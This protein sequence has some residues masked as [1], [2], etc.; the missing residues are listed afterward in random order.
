MKKKLSMIV[1]GTIFISYIVLLIAS[2]I[3]IRNIGLKGATEKALIAAELVKDGLTAHMVNGIMA[4]RDYFLGQISNASHIDELW[5]TRSPSVV[6]Q[7]GVG[8]KNEIS[9]DSIDTSVLE[10]GKTFSDVFE[11]TT[12]T[13][14]R[15]TLPYVASSSSNP[16]CLSCHDAKEGDVLG[17]I[18]VIIDISDVKV[19]GIMTSAV[20]L[21]ISLVMMFI[22]FIIISRSL[23]PLAVLFESIT[24][25]MGSA[26]EGDYSKRV[27]LIN[28]SQEYKN[29]TF[30]INSLL[31]KL[32]D[33]LMQIETT[34]K[35][36][37]AHQRSDEKDMLIELK[38]LIKEISDLHK[39]KKTIEFD[40]DK[41][42]VYTRI[43]TVLEQRFD[44][45]NF[46]L[47]EHDKRN[48]IGVQIVYGM[49]NDG[50]FTPNPQCR[51]L[52]TKQVVNSEQ[53]PNIC[54]QCSQQSSHYLC[55]PFIVSSDIEILLHVD[56]NTANEI[57]EIHKRLIGFEN[58]INEA[59]PEIVSKNLTE[60]LRISSTTDGLTGLYNRKY[61]D[62]YIDKAT[63]QAKRSKTNFGVL[64][65]DIDYFK[66]VNDTYGHDIGDEVIRVLSKIM[67]N[68]I[69]ESDI[70]FRFGGEEF[71]IL[72]HQ[73]TSDKAE[74]I[75]QKIR[76]TFEQQSIKPANAQAFSKTLSIGVSI[77]PDDADSLWKTI[78]YADISLYRAKE[79]GRNK[80]VRFDTNF[81]QDGGVSTDF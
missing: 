10:N 42:Q 66:M 68:S 41:M 55:I 69:R 64:M 43:G 71:L 26:Q 57:A 21:V 40:E 39:F 81:L 34:V 19:N 49:Q 38:D 1:L 2:A 33:T 35:D 12:E 32:Q 6:E 79:S 4:N 63:A 20:V 48:S 15:V 56:A 8:L 58:Y 72:L 51:A 70:A 59:R 23:S 18:S 50:C 47:A 52:R 9:R 54:E 31:D 73:C 30:W 46:V 61:L 11:T 14:L 80:V 77:F 74:E 22:V 36:F 27:I 7:F 45:H 65:I 28:N 5:I 24:K 75:A 17:T 62:E 3:N 13:K 53:F 25:V 44:L 60:I 78:K 67:Q 16:N 37:L 29:V 76:T